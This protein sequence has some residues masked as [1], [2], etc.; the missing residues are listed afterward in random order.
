MELVSEARFISHVCVTPERPSRSMNST[1]SSICALYY[2]TVVWWTC[3]G[4]RGNLRKI[5]Q[6]VEDTLSYRQVFRESRNN[7]SN[8]KTFAES[9]ALSETKS[10]HLLQKFYILIEWRRYSFELYWHILQNSICF[11]CV[12][13]SLRTPI[14][15]F[16]VYWSFISLNL[17]N[18][19]CS[20]SFLPIFGNVEIALNILQYYSDPLSLVC[21][22]QF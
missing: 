12:C 21:M 15:N 10:C 16:N 18:Y 4:G 1:I 20:A 9:A 5:I 14:T 2:G 19:S 13:F 7:A 6:W 17:Y 22:F 8:I 11:F 3:V